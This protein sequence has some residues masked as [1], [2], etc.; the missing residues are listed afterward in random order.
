MST[1][2][3]TLTD[4]RL[5]VPPLCLPACCLPVCL[6]AIPSG[7]FQGNTGW[8]FLAAFLVVSCGITLFTL[9]G[10]VANS[11]GLDDDEGSGAERQGYSYQRVAA[12]ERGRAV[13]HHPKGGPAP[14]PALAALEAVQRQR[15]AL[16]DH[17]GAAGD[18]PFDVGGGTGGR[19]RSAG[20]F[21]P[22][23][24]AEMDPW[25]EGAAR[26]TAALAASESPTIALAAVPPL[27]R[28][29][30]AQDDSP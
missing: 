28:R 6:R 12:A 21:L 14:D 5:R 18:N 9:C 7:G 3:T 17:A 26:H 11:G 24:T 22:L 15:Q 2:R 29:P 1:R 13:W 25:R 8:F 20:G 23:A 10:D 30:V 27:E 4:K 19:G 16:P